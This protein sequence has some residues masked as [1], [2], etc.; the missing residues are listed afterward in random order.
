MFIFKRHIRKK[1]DRCIITSS[2]RANDH[3]MKVEVSNWDWVSLVIRINTLMLMN[4]MFK[5]YVSLVFT[6]KH[7]CWKSDSQILPFGNFP[8]KTAPKKRKPILPH[9]YYIKIQILNCWKIIYYSF[10]F[11][12]KYLDFKLMWSKQIDTSKTFKISI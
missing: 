3:K 7:S 6:N 12:L 1:P 10:R 11:L 5:T 9:P 4:R 8:S 2:V